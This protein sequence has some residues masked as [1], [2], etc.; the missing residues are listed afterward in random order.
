[1]SLLYKRVLKMLPKINTILRFYMDT[2]I[3]NHFP[4]HPAYFHYFHSL[5]IAPTNES[6]PKTLFHQ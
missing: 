5:L 1:M 2:Q 3:K 6:P 4:F